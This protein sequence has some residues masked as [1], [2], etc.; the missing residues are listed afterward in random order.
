[1]AGTVPPPNGQGAPSDEQPAQPPAEKVSYWRAAQPAQP[2]PARPAPSAQ[3]P[4]GNLRTR[5]LLAGFGA[6]VTVVTIALLQTGLGLL[7]P[8]APSP[9]LPAVIRITSPPVA[10]SPSASVAP[11]TVFDD[12]Q[13]AGTG[14]RLATFTTPDGATAIADINHTGNGSF[15][16]NAVADTGEETLLVTATGGYTGNVLFDQGSTHSV[17]MSVETDGAWSI[18]IRHVSRARVWNG[19]G[20]LTGMGDDVVLITPRPTTE[21]TIAAVHSGRAGFVVIGYSEAGVV[22]VVD[23]V[24]PAD[25]GARLAAG[26]FALEVLSDGE[27]SLTAP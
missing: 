12:I 16:V 22:A 18:T 5:L 19:S 26:T 25:V 23:E 2:A 27:W 4:E 9:T 13:L 8:R 14:N 10:A 11:S 6:V 7:F 15:T 20:R 17:A 3:H 1:M 21:T 24:G